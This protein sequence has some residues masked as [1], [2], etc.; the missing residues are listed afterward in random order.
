[1]LKGDRL[2]NAGM[3]AC[4]LPC[5]SRYRTTGQLSRQS[6]RFIAL[7]RMMAV[8]RVAT[9]STFRGRFSDVPDYE[10]RIRSWKLE[11]T[12]AAIVVFLN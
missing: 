12:V 9:V 1:M 2:S 8:G 4:A 11:H 5:T 7:L 6:A 10:K 3:L